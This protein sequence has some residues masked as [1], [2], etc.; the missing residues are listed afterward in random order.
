MCARSLACIQPHRI[1]ERSEV[2]VN[3]Q[4]SGS[5]HDRLRLR[6]QLIFKCL[7]HIDDKSLQL[8]VLL[9]LLTAQLSS[10]GVAI[11]LLAE[12]HLN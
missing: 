12:N 9:V 8:I 10:I 2:P 4:G 1:L 7:A 11:G 6:V 5:E 3:G